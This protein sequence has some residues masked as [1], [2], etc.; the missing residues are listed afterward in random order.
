MEINMKENG[1]IIQ[2]Q[3]LENISQPM[4]IYMKVNLLMAIKKGKEF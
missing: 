3:E 1:K 4:E 2:F